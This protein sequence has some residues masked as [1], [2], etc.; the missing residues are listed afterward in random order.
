MQTP[1]LRKE[2]SELKKSLDKDSVA[3]AL[4]D[5]K[6]YAARSN[7]V[8]VDTLQMKLMHLD[9]TGRRTQHEDK[10]LFSKV[11]ERF[12]FHK[13]RDD[14]GDLVA[15]LLSSPSDAR[16]YDK[17]HKFLKLHRKDQK[18]EDKKP[19]DAEKHAT[20][21]VDNTKVDWQML[22]MQL[23][24]TVQLGQPRFSPPSPL[25]FRPFPAPRRQP[26]GRP[27]PSVYTGCHYCGDLSHYRIDCP[28]L[29]Q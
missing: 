6:E 9:E 14:V 4:R 27:R 7:D 20:P 29:K 28:K 24:N 23:Y 18:S 12:Q 3:F 8:N 13:K 2:F 19:G 16:L 1:D 15:N 22:Y 11:L 25:P 17:E 10:G 5:V 26:Q 21:A